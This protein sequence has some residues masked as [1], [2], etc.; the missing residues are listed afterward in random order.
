MRIGIDIDGVLSDFNS[1]YIDL[2]I[3]T[4]GR[5]LFPPAPFDIPTWY[6]PELYKYSTDEIEKVWATIKNS[7]SFWLDLPMYPDTE[8]SMFYLRKQWV[9]GNDIY[10]ITSR[11]GATSKSQTE[12]WLKN[13][14]EYGGMGIPNP[15]VLISSAK[16][17]CAKALDLDYYIDDRWENCCDVIRESPRTMTYLLDRSWNRNRELSSITRVKQLKGFVEV[18]CGR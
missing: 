15:T 1:R 3:K 18:D 7:K 12:Q 13:I 11:P 9:K 16:G 8:T 17:L 14:D 2:I 5:D 10:F 4:S 6:Y